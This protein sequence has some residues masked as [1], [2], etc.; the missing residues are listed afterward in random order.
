[1]SIYVFVYGTLRAGEI[2][3]LA[4]AA[5]RRRL[6]PARYVGPASVP[7]RL[8][9]FGDWP[10]LIPVADGRRVRGDVF[11]VEPALIALM[12]EIEEY[13]PGKP[14]CF[15]RR[16]VAARLEFPGEGPPEGPESGGSLTCQYYPID[17]ALRGEAV[18]VA[19]DDW[20]C[21]RRARR[22]PGCP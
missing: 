11:E 5:A 1:M 12:D 21:Y 14:C 8:V 22:L 18:D 19:A 9:D 2:N 20:I 4:Q 17:P 15:V 16:E 13:E 10:G 3:D 7:G 6:P